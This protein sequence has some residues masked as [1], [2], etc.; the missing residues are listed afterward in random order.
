MSF[1][2]RGNE[3]LFSK[4]KEEIS[5]KQKK[6]YFIKMEYASWFWLRLRHSDVI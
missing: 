5:E 6:Y 2:K 1:F 3:P 4:K